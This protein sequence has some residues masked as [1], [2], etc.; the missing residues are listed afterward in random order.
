MRGVDRLVLKSLTG[1]VVVASLVAGVWLYQRE[2][3]C[4]QTLKNV[5]G[6]SDVQ[7]RRTS[8]GVCYSCREGGPL[9]DLMY[10]DCGPGDRLYV[11]RWRLNGG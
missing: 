9:Y 3:N 6:L 8:A 1:T 10:R 2:N 11:G 5:S 7:V 4:T